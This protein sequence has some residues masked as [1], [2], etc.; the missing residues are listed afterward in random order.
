MDDVY[1]TAL[2]T[3]FSAALKML[4]QAIEDC[5]N[6]LWFDRQQYQ[7]PFWHIAY[8]VLFYTHLYL[9]PNEAQFAPWEQAQE[10]YHYLGKVSWQPD[11]NP[12]QTTPYNKEAIL[13]YW[14]YCQQQ[15]H[16]QLAVV[17]FSQ[18]SGFDWIPFGKLELQL[19]N[20]RHLQQHS[21]ELSERLGANGQI[22]VQW[23]GR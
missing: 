11:Y 6:D 4:K 18:P 12:Q 1:R 23:I 22:E 17:D 16:V 8:H 2:E 20:L 10:H 5:P 14:A 19:Y 3:Q 7:N 21:G 9:S 13:A 15:V